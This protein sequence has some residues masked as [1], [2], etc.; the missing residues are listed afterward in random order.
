M[1]KGFNQEEGIDFNATS[2]LII[3]ITSVRVILA[4]DVRN[5]WK[6]QQLDVK[7]SFLNGYLSK[8]V[9]MK[10]LI[11]FIHKNEQMMFFYYTKLYMGL[12]KPL[13]L[14]TQVYIYFY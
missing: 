9:C 7:N 4:L 2:S 13:G 3:K 8:T 12:S 11:G 5:Y 10:Q 1:A 14:G 6:F